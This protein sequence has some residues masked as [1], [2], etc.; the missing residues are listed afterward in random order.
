MAGNVAVV[1]HIYLHELLARKKPAEMGHILAGGG[2]ARA[3]FVV[4]RNDQDLADLERGG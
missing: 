4:L 2:V 3:V 1:P